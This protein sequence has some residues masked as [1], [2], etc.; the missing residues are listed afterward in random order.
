VKTVVVIDD[1][2]QIVEVLAG[3]LKSAGFEV[4]T[5]T[6]GK[7]GLCLINETVPD[8]VV[9]DLRMP[10]MSGADVIEQ[11]KGQPRTAQVPVLLITSYCIPE[12]LGVGDALLLKPVKCNELVTTVLHLAARPQHLNWPS[13]ISTA[14]FVPVPAPTRAAPRAS[15]IPRGPRKI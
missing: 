6:S 5:A 2:E 11:I 10:G 8:A 4:R 1:D 13:E 12:M 3:F 9:C 7:A 14:D 15:K